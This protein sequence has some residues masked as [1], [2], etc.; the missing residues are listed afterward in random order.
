MP[1]RKYTDGRPP[2]KRVESFADLVTRA[3]PEP[4]SGCLIWSMGRDRLGYGQVSVDRRR[5]GAHRLAWILTHGPIPS[6]LSVMHSCDNPPCINPDHLSLGT[7]A[8]N[9]HDAAVKGRARNQTT[10]RLNSART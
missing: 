6:G 8:E 5:F 1:D 4:H 9:M 7:H 3:V 2:R 10:G